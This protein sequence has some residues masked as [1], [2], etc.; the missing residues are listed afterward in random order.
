MDYYHQ[1]I[2]LSPGYAPAYFNLGLIY[3]KQELNQKALAMF[4]LAVEKDSSFIQA[5][6]ARDWLIG[7]IDGMRGR[8]A[9]PFQSPHLK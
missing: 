9:H 3:K 1:V 7:N 6:R 5:Q 2:R 4:S 8:K